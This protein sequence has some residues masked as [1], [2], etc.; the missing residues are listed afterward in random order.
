MGGNGVCFAQ[1]CAPGAG[2]SAWQTAGTHI[3][4]MNCMGLLLWA[5][6]HAKCSPF[7][8]NPPKSPIIRWDHY[9]YFTRGETEAQKSQVYYGRQ[10]GK[11]GNGSTLLQGPSA[12]SPATAPP[13]FSPP[14]AY[15]VLSALNEIPHLEVQALK[16]WARRT[17]SSWLVRVNLFLLWVVHLH[18][19]KGLVLSTHWQQR[20]LAGFHSLQ[21]K[22]A[23]VL[24]K[25]F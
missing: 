6:H 15:G 14:P 3:C 1:H 22:Y 10:N 8:L 24:P 18:F 9:P 19:R 20:P 13:G 21:L 2:E 25:P 7:S 4:W 11:T 12:R 17:R 16:P 5:R 23:L